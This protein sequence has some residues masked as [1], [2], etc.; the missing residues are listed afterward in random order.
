VVDRAFDLG[1]TSAW[2]V[3]QFEREPIEVVRVAKTV[4]SDFN[5]NGHYD[6]L[7]V[8]LDMDVIT[9]GYY[10][11]SASLGDSQGTELGFATGNTYLSGNSTITM[12]FP[13][14][15]I[16][17]NAVDGPFLIKNFI[18]Y[19]S[20]HSRIINLV[21]KTDALSAAL[22]EGYVQPDT[23]PPVLTLGVTPSEIWP[24]NHQMVEVPVSYDV[25]DNMD[26]APIVELVSVTS[27]DG[28]NEIGDGNHSPDIDITEDGRIFVRAERAGPKES[29]IY[30][31][32]Y[33][34]RDAAGNTALEEITVTVL[35]DKGM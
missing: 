4:G 7:S 35:H 10:R 24:P 31:I 20:G 9:S 11:W 3:S 2:S 14:T 8:I 23:E 27:S 16:G 33:S 6:R 30:T 21:G 25:T 32:T 1:Q 19:G 29:R 22:F 34:A 15:P 18:I 12:N 13:G 28:E 5:N 17:E 26:P